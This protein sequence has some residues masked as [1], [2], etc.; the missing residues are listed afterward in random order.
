MC[1]NHQIPLSRVRL[2]CMMDQ[3]T[4]AAFCGDLPTLSKHERVMKIP[5]IF[6]VCLLIYLLSL[7]LSPYCCRS[8]PHRHHLYPS[9][10]A[11]SKMK[12]QS[13]HVWSMEYGKSFGGA[14]LSSSEIHKSVMW[15]KLN[16]FVSPWTLE[17]F[18]LYNFKKTL[19]KSVTVNQNRALSF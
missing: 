17:R 13:S 11:S 9:A 10:M 5:R 18:R 12:M 1:H 19:L 7:I 3:I 16:F 6:L 14:Q 4:D 8:S 2:I 15:V